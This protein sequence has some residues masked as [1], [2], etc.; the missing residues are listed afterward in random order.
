MQ[1]LALIIA[2]MVIGYITPAEAAC[3]WTHDCSSG[4]CRQVQICDRAYD[5]PA[6]RPPAIAPIAPPSIRPVPRPTVPPVGTQSCGQRYLC[7]GGQC[8]WQTVCR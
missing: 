1:R 3:R 4:K 5:A 6:I 8:S 7:S 2:L